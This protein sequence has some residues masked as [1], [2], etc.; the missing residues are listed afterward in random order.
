MQKKYRIAI[1]GIG[2]VGGFIGGKLAASHSHSDDVEVIFIAR[3]DNGEAI[4]EHGLKLITPSGET[5]VYPDMVAGA[6]TA[7][8]E[9]DLLICCTKTYDLESGVQALSSCIT[10]RTMV[11]PLLNG[12]DSTEKLRSLVPSAN[13]LQGCIYLV[14]KLISPGVVQQRGEFHSLHFNGDKALPAELSG[15]LDLFMKSGINAVVEDN[16]HEK[17]WS[18]FSFIS[19][20]ATYT[21]AYDISVGKILESGE[22]SMAIKT[23]MAELV[24][25]AKTLDIHLAADV[26][27][28][29][30]LV[31]GKLPYEATSSMHADFA[32]NKPT[33]L[34]TLTGSVVRKAKEKGIRLDAYSDIYQ[35]LSKQ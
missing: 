33:E 13:I 17:V 1:L 7:M 5:T 25:L 18:K 20:V 34:E 2:G 9:I 14:S 22:H 29:N 16:I 3:G 23:L 32:A 24:G 28:N 27:E 35:L 6:G 31:M 11:L 30:F 15:L 10:S 19:P 4:K 21:S 8:G 26:I 12:I